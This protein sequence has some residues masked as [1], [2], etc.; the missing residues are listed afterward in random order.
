MTEE[1]KQIPVKRYPRAT[2]HSNYPTKRLRVSKRT[3]DGTEPTVY[4]EVPNLDRI[5]HSDWP[6]VMDVEQRK[7]Y[8]KRGLEIAATSWARA[9][10][11]HDLDSKIT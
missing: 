11:A 2:Y 1:S 6:S 7:E 8:L 4:V 3:P 5:H 9:M 10:L